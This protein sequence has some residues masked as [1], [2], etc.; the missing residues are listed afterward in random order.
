M[1]TTLAERTKPVQRYTNTKIK[2]DSCKYSNS[3]MIEIKK[4]EKADRYFYGEKCPRCGHFD[5]FKEISKI[6]ARRYQIFEDL[7]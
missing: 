4:D 7:L 6:E 3:F 2:C 5:E 1:M